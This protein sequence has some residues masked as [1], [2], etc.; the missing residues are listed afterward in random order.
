V[1]LPFFPALSMKLHVKLPKPGIKVIP[2]GCKIESPLPQISQMKGVD[3]F[4]L[5]PRVL[6][7]STEVFAKAFVETA[8]LTMLVLNLLVVPT[9]FIQYC[10]LWSIL[11][12][13]VA[14]L[15]IGRM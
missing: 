15:K 3:E 9:L 8:S 7:E 1:I 10:I 6:I 13:S 14:P 4:V 11:E 2:S 12:L 5:S